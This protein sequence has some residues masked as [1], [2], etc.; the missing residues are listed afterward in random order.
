MAHEDKIKL[1]IELIK[2]FLYIVTLIISIA[3]AFNSMDRRISIIESEMKY[4]VNTT[5]LLEKLDQVKDEINKKIESEISKV[6]K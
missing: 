1:A 6:N 4:K 5:L 2:F 3:F